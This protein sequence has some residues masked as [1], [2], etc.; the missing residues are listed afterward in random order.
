[1]NLNN[2]GASDANHDD[3]RPH[4]SDKKNEH[5]KTTA[6]L[7]SS[8]KEEVEHSQQ[9]YDFNKVLTH[10]PPSKNL[11]YRPVNASECSDMLSRGSS[12]QESTLRGNSE[13]NHS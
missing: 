4:T 6:L 1:M 3:Q 9:S 10:G 2:I 7:D 13:W 12:L 8:Q 5:S 11:N